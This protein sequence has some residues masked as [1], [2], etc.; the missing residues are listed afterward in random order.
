MN[1]VR[2]GDDGAQHPDLPLPVACWHRRI[3][4]A[5]LPTLTLGTKY[6]SQSV[7]DPV[8]R[9]NGYQENPRGGRRKSR[10]LEFDAC[11]SPR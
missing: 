11:C 2:W 3:S 5:S 10:W 7:P 4:L 8:L 1:D 9:S 6:G